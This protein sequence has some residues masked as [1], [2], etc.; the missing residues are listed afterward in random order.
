MSVKVEKTENKNE[1]KLSFEIEA[2][3]FEDAMKKVYAKTAKYFTIPGFR[4]G[5]APMAIVERTYG[6]SI[7]Y[8]DTF[9]ELVPDIYD[10]AIKEN[11]IEAVSRPQIDISQMEKGKDLKF[12]AIVQIKPEVKLGKY[13]GIEL[14]KIE[15]TV[16][17][18]DVEHELGHMAEH[19]AR[20]VTV[21]DR[22]VEKGDITIIDF[23]GSIDEVAFEGGTATNQELEIGSNKFIPGF[24]DQIIGMKVNEEKDI[25]VTFPEDY[26]SKDLAGKEA[27][28]KVT[29]HEIKKK[30]LPKIDDDFAKDVSE[31]DTLADLKADIKSKME[32]ENEERAKY[33]SEEAAIEAVCKDVEVDIPSGMIE[34]EID[35][36]VKDIENK[37]SYQGLTLD[38][39][40]KLTNKTMENLRKEFDE[41]ANKAVKSR[42]VLEAIIKAEDIKPDDKEVEEKVKEMA[43]NY[44]R[45]EDELLKNEGFKNYIVDNM[46]Y[47]KAIAFILDNAKMKK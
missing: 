34:T 1:V 2:E 16:S 20:L 7:F 3:K 43:K 31:F 13:K 42:L 22:P 30:E 10:E 35:N 26:F 18:K 40:L 28:F 29:L 23:A 38:Q 27:T 6:S 11:K 46:K 8:E 33:E 9:N 25:N 4:K 5:K 21:D 15:Y 19:N 32:K 37:L 12:T 44:G 24:E 39:Y 47:E 17:D 45:P 41:Q 14:K 36:M